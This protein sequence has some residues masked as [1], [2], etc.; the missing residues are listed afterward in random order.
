MVAIV[1]VGFFFRTTCSSSC[2][3]LSSSPI[4]IANLA[5][6]PRTSRTAPSNT[7]L[8]IFWSKSASRFLVF[9]KHVLQRHVHRDVHVTR[10]VYEGI[11]E[12]L[13]Y[14]IACTDMHLLRYDGSRIVR[15]IQ[16]LIWILVSM[17]GPFRI[18]SMH[19]FGDCIFTTPSHFMSCSYSSFGDT[20]FT[21]L[22][23]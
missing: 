17:L 23:V 20:S 10:H 13:F 18:T 6:H 15:D 7:T 1:L 19:I 21:S 4:L 9:D 12:L 14:W 3:F 5:G 11:F 22:T 16:R 2:M 8:A